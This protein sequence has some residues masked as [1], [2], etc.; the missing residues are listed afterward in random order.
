VSAA[1]V[2]T[3][4]LYNRFRVQPKTLQA[5]ADAEDGEL[6]EVDPSELG[7]FLPITVMSGQIDRI[8]KENAPKKPKKRQEEDELAAALAAQ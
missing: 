3:V 4:I 7:E 2:K 6:I 1:K 8:V 5:I